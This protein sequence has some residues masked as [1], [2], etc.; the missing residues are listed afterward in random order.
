MAT[1]AG[2]FKVVQ[3]GLDQGRA[4]ELAARLGISSEELKKRLAGGA[5]LVEKLPE[6][7]YEVT[8]TDKNKTV[9]ETIK[10]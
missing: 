4:D 8:V 7:E 10:Y 3:L 9:T 5:L 6:A 2:T 1:I